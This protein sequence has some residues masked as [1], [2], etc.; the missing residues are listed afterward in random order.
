MATRMAVSYHRDG[1][2]A[3][4]GAQAGHPATHTPVVPGWPGRAMCWA[5]A[6]P[7]PSICSRPSE[8][9]KSPGVTGTVWVTWLAST[10]SMPGWPPAVVTS[11]VAGTASTPLT[12]AVVTA[13]VTGAWSTVPVAAGS[14]GVMSTGAVGGGDG[15][16]GPPPPDVAVAP[17]VA[18][19][20]A[21]VWAAPRVMVTRSPVWTWDRW[22]A[23]R[24]A[25]TSRAG[26]VPVSAGPP[27]TVAPGVA[28]TVVTRTGVGRT[29]T[30]PRVR[31][32]VWE[33]PRRA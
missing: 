12:V 18:T 19:T 28:D 26:E 21:V 6:R 24:V 7:V 5:T 22:V 27:A 30:W 14:V 2:R 20:P 16:P 3:V 32:P 25:V 8:S 11:A 9:S 13:T 17:T 33:A 1:T 29:V 31:L 15:P 10:T 23:G 4:T